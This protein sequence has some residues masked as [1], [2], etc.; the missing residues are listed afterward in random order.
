MNFLSLSTVEKALSIYI[1][2]MAALVIFC[3]VRAVKGPR[4]TNRVVAVNV[5]G[6]MATAMIC[7][8][9]AMLHEDFLADVAIVY[10]LLNFISVVVLCRVVTL[11]HK[12][13]LMH[14]KGEKKDDN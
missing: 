14:I 10:A 1:M 5:I 13:R 2:V 8:L 4:F 6:T 11:H 3:L 12:G 9:S 7:A